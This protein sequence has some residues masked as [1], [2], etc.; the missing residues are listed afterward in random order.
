M[1]CCVPSD[2]MRGEDKTEDRRQKEK[3]PLCRVAPFFLCAIKLW[4]KFWG[5][6]RLRFNFGGHKWQ[7]GYDRGC[8]QT[9][10]PM[11]LF[12]CHRLAHAHLCVCVCIMWD[13][14]VC[15]GGPWDAKVPCWWFARSIKLTAGACKA[16][17][18]APSTHLTPISTLHRVPV[19]P[20]YTL[21]SPSIPSHTHATH[22][23]RSNKVFD[24][25]N[26]TS[27][28]EEDIWLSDL[29][30]SHWA[31]LSICKLLL[32]GWWLFAHCCGCTLINLLEETKQIWFKD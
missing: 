8:L 6:E 17:W 3:K 26:K 28:L 16:T 1:S 4:Q 31:A 27:P 12:I 20:S 22:T 29:H 15:V 24:L 13:R 18:S 10:G 25:H 5:W 32:N 9:E 7:R 14:C 30:Q 21:W 11:S 2:E 23:E 19:L